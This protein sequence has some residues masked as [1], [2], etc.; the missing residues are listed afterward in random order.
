MVLLLGLFVGKLLTF[1]GSADCSGTM[2]E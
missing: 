1:D 2:A